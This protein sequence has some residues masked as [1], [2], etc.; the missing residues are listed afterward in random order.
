MALGLATDK[1]R[2]VAEFYAGK[3]LFITG[4]TGFLGKVFI[5]KLL[6]SCADIDKIYVLVRNK[7]YTNAN[8]RIE[9]MLNNPLFTRLKKKRPD[10]TTKL[11]PIFGDVSEPNLGITP[12]DEQLLIE[13]V[14]IVFHAAATVK[15]NEILTEALQINVDGTRNVLDLCHKMN[16]IEMLVHISTLYSNCD[17]RIIEEIV[18]PPPIE[19]NDLHTYI[20]LNMHD[21]KAIGDIL[22]GR[23]NTYTFTKAL[24]EALVKEKHGNIPTIIIR[25]SIVGSVNNEPLP[26][27]LD[28]WYGATCL[29]AYM[30]TG[31]MRVLPGKRD[32]VIDFI[33]VDYVSNLT[34]V[35]AAKTGRS[36][37]LHVYNSCTSGCNPITLND[38]STILFKQVLKDNNYYSIFPK[39]LFI[40][41]K[42]MLK[43]F[44]FLLE[45]VPAYLGDIWLRL[46]GGKPSATRR[47]TPSLRFE[48]VDAMSW[49]GRTS[50]ARSNKRIILICDPA[51]KDSIQPNA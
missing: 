15:F 49:G 28:N 13:K 10:C 48:D 42:S 40:T 34:I 50:Q 36:K 51:R 8:N 37:L 47:R 12:A 17:K 44:R 11:I 7:K 35:A 1:Y 2:S 45:T 25:P 39:M 20:K 3:S 33:P 46:T 29:L 23:P 19:L 18:Y 16:K 5:E 14:S 21:E 9:Q 41:S 31:I 43:L 22:S 38:V 4:G 30:G 26:G 32:G 6:Y 24:A 27:W